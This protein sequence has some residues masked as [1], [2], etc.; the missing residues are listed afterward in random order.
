MMHLIALIRGLSM[1]L[2]KKV[3]KK[4]RMLLLISR[5]LKDNKLMLRQFVSSLQIVIKIK[6]NANCL[7]TEN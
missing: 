2:R 3:I 4:A 7:K 5:M 6:K 1:G